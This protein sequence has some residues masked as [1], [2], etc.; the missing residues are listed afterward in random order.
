MKAPMMQ[1]MQGMRG[2]G[3]EDSGEIRDLGMNWE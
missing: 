1:R 3:G 2:G